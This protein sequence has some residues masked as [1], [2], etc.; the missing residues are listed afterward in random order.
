LRWLARATPSAP[1]GTSLVIVEPAA[2]NASASTVTGATRLTLQ[3]MKARSPTAVRCFF[4][5]S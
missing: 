4:W 3:P 1:L 2:T 5:P